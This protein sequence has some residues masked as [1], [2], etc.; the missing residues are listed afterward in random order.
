MWLLPSDQAIE[1]VVYVDRTVAEGFWMDGG[2]GWPGF[3][4]DLHP[5]PRRVG[6]KGYTQPVGTK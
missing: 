6:Q 3:A 1:L 5:A 2:P 4:Q